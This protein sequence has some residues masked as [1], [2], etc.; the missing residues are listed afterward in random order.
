MHH[1][2][3]C[4]AA[5]YCDSE[6]MDNGE[7]PCAKHD[8]ESEECQPEFQDYADDDYDEFNDEVDE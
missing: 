8:G 7:F 5:C 6:D 2:P 1:C 4:G 3:Y